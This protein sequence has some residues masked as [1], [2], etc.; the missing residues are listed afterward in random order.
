MSETTIA[1][2]VILMWNPAATIKRANELSKKH[3]KGKLTESE[4]QELYMLLRK[5]RIAYE[6]DV[7]PDEVEWDNYDEYPYSEEDEIDG[8]DADEEE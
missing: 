7:D 3:Q 8:E 4:K 6:Y 2:K 1:I 5:H